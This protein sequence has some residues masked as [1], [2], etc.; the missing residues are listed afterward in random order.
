M[1]LVA[2]TADYCRR[3]YDASDESLSQF[4]CFAVNVWG[5]NSEGRDDAEVA[6]AGIEALDAWTRGVGAHR[7][8]SELSLKA[9]QVDELAA[10]VVCL[11]ARTARNR[12]C[13]CHSA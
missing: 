12:R 5:V 2:I 9:E 6:L 4:R 11:P 8:P 7:T 3:I 1:G 10:S 13:S